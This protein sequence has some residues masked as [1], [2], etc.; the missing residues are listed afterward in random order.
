MFFPNLSQKEVFEQW[1]DA[2]RRGAYLQGTGTLRLLRDDAPPQYCC[3][4]V[5]CDLDTNY[6]QSCW[7]P[8]GFT[9][10][11]RHGCVAYQDSFLPYELAKWLNISSAHQVEL[12]AMNDSEQASFLDI[13][14]YIETVVMPA[15]LATAD[16]V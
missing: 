5:L 7:A 11:D 14:K 8:Q 13:A 1:I 12:Y 15:S 2:L 9:Y 4:G 6:N 16:M 10:T 3:I